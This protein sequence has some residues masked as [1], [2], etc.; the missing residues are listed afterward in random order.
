MP[1]R[2]KGG[3]IDEDWHISAKN[4]LSDRKA[5]ISAKGARS[6][7]VNIPFLGL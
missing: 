5:N 2:G 4:Y 3:K 6:R 1:K 7:K